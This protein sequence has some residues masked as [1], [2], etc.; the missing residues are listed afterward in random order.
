MQQPF[1]LGHRD[2]RCSPPSRST[3]SSTTT[4]GWPPTCLGPAVVAGAGSLVVLDAGDVCHL[5]TTPRPVPD[6][7]LLVMRTALRQRVL[8]EASLLAA[9]L[10][11]LYLPRPCSR[12]RSPLDLGT[13]DM[14][15]GPSRTVAAWTTDRARRTGPPSLI[16][17]SQRHPGDRAATGM[18]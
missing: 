5:D 4:V 6:G 10:P 11:I 13:A 1:T 2:P 9:R 7:M 15:I 8:I 3:A 16:R 14:L 18:E 12:N 17:S